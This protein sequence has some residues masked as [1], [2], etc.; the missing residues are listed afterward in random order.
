MCNDIPT[1]IKDAPAYCFAQSFLRQF[2]INILIVQKHIAWMLRLM[3]CMSS[4]ATTRKEGRTET[5][6]MLSKAQGRAAPWALFIVYI[7]N[8]A[9]RIINQ[10][11]T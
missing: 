5:T 7:F 11:L 4:A 1:V 8:L 10:I 2:D 6:G 3:R 9:G